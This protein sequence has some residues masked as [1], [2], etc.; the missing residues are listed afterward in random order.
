MHEVHNNLKFAKDYIPDRI[1]KEYSLIDRTKA[2]K[3]IHFPK[4]RESLKRARERL[5]FDE[6]FLYSLALRRMRDSKAISRTEYPMNEADECERLIDS[7]PYKLT[8]AQHLVWSEIKN[9][10]TS[11][12]AMN[13]LV[14]GDVVRERL[15]WHCLHY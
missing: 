7:L 6:F 14:Q 8:K 5:V 11:E 12:L 4:D 2:L 15:F 10:L 1:S 9:D 13:R 3:E